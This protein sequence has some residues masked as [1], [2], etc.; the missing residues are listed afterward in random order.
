MNIRDTLMDVSEVMKCLGRS[1]SYSYR[2]ISQLNKELEA[3]GYLTEAGRVPR[4]Y[5]Y[6]RYGL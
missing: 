4:K 2:I 3:K 5:L 1:Q 6:E